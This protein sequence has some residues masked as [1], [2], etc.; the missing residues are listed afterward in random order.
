MSP[1]QVAELWEE[2]KKKSTELEDKYREIVR[3][4]GVS[5]CLY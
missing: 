4:R 1:G 3:A 5:L 2:E